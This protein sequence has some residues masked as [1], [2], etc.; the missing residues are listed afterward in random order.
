MGGLFHRHKHKH[1]HHADVE[2]KQKPKHDLSHKQGAPK[3]HIH[4]HTE[5][6]G[7]NDNDHE[8]AAEAIVLNE[9]PCANDTNTNIAAAAA[10]PPPKVDGQQQQQLGTVIGKILM[11][12]KRNRH[13]NTNSN[14]R[15]PQ[16]QKEERQPQLEQEENITNL[17]YQLESRGTSNR[18][19]ANNLPPAAYGCWQE[20][21][22]SMT[23]TWMW[24]KFHSFAHDYYNKC[25]EQHLDCANVPASG[26]EAYNGNANAENGKEKQKRQEM[27][28][29]ID[30]C[31]DN[32]NNNHGLPIQEVAM[33]A[34]VVEDDLD[35]TAGRD[36][37]E[38]METNITVASR[39]SETMAED[40][41]AS[42]STEDYFI[43]AQ[44]MTSTYD[45]NDDSD[46]VS[47]LTLEEAFILRERRAF[48]A[49][50][51]DSDLSSS[52]DDGDDARNP[53]VKVDA[54]QFA[55]MQ[56]D[57]NLMQSKLH[58][59]RVLHSNK[60]EP[61]P[62]QRH[63][64]S[65]NNVRTGSPMPQAHAKNRN[66]NGNRHLNVNKKKGGVVVQ[67]GR[68]PSPTRGREGHQQQHR[69]TRPRSPI[70]N[71]T[72]GN[73]LLFSNK[74]KRKN[75]QHRHPHQQE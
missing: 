60:D 71:N 53:Q 17:L 34:A 26:G 46:T 4:V 5:G 16:N 54:R 6:K 41:L 40:T 67:Y 7:K 47:R 13:T 68:S 65:A 8:H 59:V 30:Y 11:D 32:A 75:K 48:T 61:Q 10:V 21:T 20:I 49:Q 12:H 1:Q 18:A 56:R 42:I 14:S 22:Q 24:V 45:E 31:N 38:T 66:S 19:Q 70:R 69:P 36:A 57:L 64:S 29:D 50:K 44:N 3:K 2:K 73:S 28:H 74:N 51:H 43:M 72:G 37:V 52:H 33:P 58:A 27:E 23:N 35:G 55:Q 9:A 63:N 25:A 62:Q 15:S 39:G